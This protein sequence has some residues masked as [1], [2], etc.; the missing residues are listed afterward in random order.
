MKEEEKE[1]KFID[2]ATMTFSAWLMRVIVGGILWSVA[3]FFARLGLD[4]Y[5]KQDKD[6]S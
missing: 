2:P 1:K 3:G 5:F 4:K 6:Q